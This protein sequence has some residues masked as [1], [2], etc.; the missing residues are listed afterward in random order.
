MPL[1]TEYE[2]KALAGFYGNLPDFFVSLFQPVSTSVFL[3]PACGICPFSGFFIPPSVTAALKRHLRLIIGEKFLRNG[4]KRGKR[5]LNSGQDTP[6]AMTAGR[7][8]IFIFC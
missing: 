5:F 1:P 4:Q 6:A 8:R 2:P 7:F 3:F